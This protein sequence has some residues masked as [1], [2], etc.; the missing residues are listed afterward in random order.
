MRERKKRMIEDFLMN[1]CVGN[2]HKKVYEIEVE[3][4]QNR[5]VYII[6]WVVKNERRKI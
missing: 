3:K 2:T 1:D 6:R 4:E 5:F